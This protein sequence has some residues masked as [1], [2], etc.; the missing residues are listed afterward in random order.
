MNNLPRTQQIFRSRLRSIARV[1]QG[2]LVV[3]SGALLWA[4]GGPQTS[5]GAGSTELENQGNALF[6]PAASSDAQPGVPAWSIVVVAFA[7]VDPNTGDPIP[8]ETVRAVADQAL[9]KARTVG[10]LKEAYIE[11]RSGRL[12]VAYGRYPSAD[13]PRA[14]ADLKRLRSMKIGDDTPFATA[15]LTPPD[16]GDLAGKPEYDLRGAR[17]TFGPE[18]IY[19]LQVGVYG[20]GDGRAASAAELAEFRKAAEQAVA[21]LRVQGE[22]AFFYHGPNRSMVTIGVFTDD[23]FWINQKTTYESPMVTA[24]RQRHPFNLLNG[25]GIRERVAALPES[26][27]RAWRIQPSRLIRIPER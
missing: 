21:T 9:A 4:C 2:L 13:D 12:V 23:D 27:P 18:A 20:R 3:V 14:Q 6:S 16:T 26:D 11:D 1:A 24:A 8:V 5:P 22:E 10:G 25:R 19:S 17:A 7:N 15:M